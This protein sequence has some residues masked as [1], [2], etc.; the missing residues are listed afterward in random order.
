M[1][2]LVYP[3]GTTFA[4]GTHD[5]WDRENYHGFIREVASNMLTRGWRAGGDYEYVAEGLRRPKILASYCRT[6]ENYAAYHTDFR[7]PVDELRRIEYPWRWKDATRGSDPRNPDLRFAFE[8][9]MDAGLYIE[10]YRLAAPGRP[11][12]K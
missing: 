7:V 5:W 10:A 2:L 12:R 8:V 11:R 4:P 9:L 3:S 6:I 1:P